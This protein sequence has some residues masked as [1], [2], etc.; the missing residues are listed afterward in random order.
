VNIGQ[1]RP[2]EV[3]RGG[4]CLIVDQAN[5]DMLASAIKKSL[6]D[7]ETYER[8]VAEAS[9]REFGSWSG[10]IDRFVKY[11]EAPSSSPVVIGTSC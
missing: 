4:G 11:L 10:Y 9:A 8:L 3:A 6:A 7:S 1:C 2:V 5:E